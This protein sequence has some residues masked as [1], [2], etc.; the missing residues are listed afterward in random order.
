LQEERSNHLAGGACLELQK[1]ADL[2]QRF[3]L[4]QWRDQ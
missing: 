3:E 4:Q 1:R 2:P